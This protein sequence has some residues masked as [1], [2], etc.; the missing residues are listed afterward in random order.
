M[1]TYPWECATHPPNELDCSRQ[2]REG[3]VSL[4]TSFRHLALRSQLGH[5]RFLQFFAFM[6][7]GGVSDGAAV[8]THPMPKFDPDAPARFLRTVFAPTDWVAIFLKSYVAS[9]VAQRVG[10]V[11]WIQSER[12]QRW[13]RAMNARKY[14]VFVSVNAIS[15]PQRMP[16]RIPMSSMLSSRSRTTIVATAL[17]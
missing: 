6:E 17:M 16:T 1:A 9:G 11:S 3:P 13:L 7:Q 12:F 15:S 2:P 10:P 8:R 14:N 4:V 5:D